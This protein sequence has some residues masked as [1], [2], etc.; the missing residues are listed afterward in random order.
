M[1]AHVCARTHAHI[2]TYTNTFTQ[3]IVL[4]CLTFLLNS[5]TGPD[6]DNKHCRNVNT[7]KLKNLCYV[8][9]Q[10]AQTFHRKICI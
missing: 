5:Y 1:H 9:D 4:F 7:N 8:F 3:I 6:D 2:V 10:S